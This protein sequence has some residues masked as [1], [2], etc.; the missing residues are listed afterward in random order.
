MYQKSTQKKASDCNNVLKDEKG[1]DRYLPHKDT[2]AYIL[3][4]AHAYHVEKELPETI[5][6]LILN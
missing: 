6:G 4:F 1:G 5:S 2:L 3:Q